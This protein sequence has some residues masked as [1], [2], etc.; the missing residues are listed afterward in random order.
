[1]KK[2]I[3][4]NILSLMALG[5]LAVSCNDWLDSVP[6]KSGIPEET[7]WETE[8][9]A[10]AYLNGFYTYIDKYGQFGGNQYSGA[11]T[12]SL[13][14]AFKYGT[15]TL[16]YRAGHENQY[17]M[18]PEVITV[19][20]NHLSLWSTAYTNIRR[21]NQYLRDMKLYSTYGE[22]KE[23]VWEA[24]A[25]FLRA[26]V[27]FNLAKRHPGVILYEEMPT[28]GQKARCTEEEMWDFIEAD[29]EYAA[30]YLPEKWDAA[31]TGRVT[32]G[33]VK[34]F[35]SRVFLYAKRWQ[36]AYDAAVEVEKLEQKGIYG[37]VSDYTQ[38]WK[39]SNKEAILEF[40]HRST[41]GPGHSFDQNYV[42]ACDGYEYGATGTPT[43]E[44]VECYETKDGKKFDWTPWH[45]G[46]STSRPP[47]EILEPRFAASVI[48]PGSVW[49]GRTMD[50]CVGG[51]NGEYTDYDSE[52]Y[53]WGKTVTGYF[54]KKLLDEKLIDVKGT[55]SSQTWV[56][57]RYAEVLLNKA[58]AAYMLDL[59]PAEYQ[60]PMNRVRDRVG[61][62]AKESTGEDWF[63]DYRNERKVEL[64]YEGHLY[65]D[66]VRWRLC[67]IEYN[68][69]RCHGFKIEDGKYTYVDV[70][71]ADRRFL[72]RQ[73]VV[74]IPA[75]EIRNNSLIEQFPEWK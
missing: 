40:Y 36:K 68:N 62:P 38:A 10:V 32:Y 6:N 25:R 1:M 52:P 15:A 49:K 4:K 23:Q 9:N 60:N 24:Q 75:D 30:K 11:L 14:D 2:S 18:K 22:E 74:P 67:H 7:V 12:E 31:N 21:I 27:Y 43:Q 58:E 19:G 42:P 26:L 65:W 56:D 54:L 53:S 8:K 33:A 51:V 59:D 72:E 71:N 44:M 57:I 48:Y 69:Y 3:L 39:G 63:A 64:A 13:T 47:F 34:A 37:L 35:E 45:E 5:A 55:A 50:C 41:N 61:L 70:D 66:M 28:D 29:L 73:Y 16:G 46:D 20:S 17:V